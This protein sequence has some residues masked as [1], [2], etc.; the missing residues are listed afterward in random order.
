QV[1]TQ[2]PPVEV[3]R[4][5]DL[6]GI[7]IQLEVEW[8]FVR[9]GVLGDAAAP[10]PHHFAAVSAPV[11]SI[12]PSPPG[13]SHPG[14][15]ITGGDLHSPLHIPNTDLAV[16]GPGGNPLA[17]WTPAQLGPRLQLE[18]LSSG[19]VEGREGGVPRGA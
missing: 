17:V 3:L 1:G 15:L 11:E 13:A 6:A 14:N 2:A 16:S 18:R 12:R 10:R 19:A 7:R 8:K 9:A 4:P 5:N